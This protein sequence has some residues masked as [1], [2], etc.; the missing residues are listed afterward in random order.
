MKG[1]QTKLTVPNFIRGTL[2]PINAAFSLLVIRYGMIKSGFIMIFIL[3]GVA[4]LALSR[5][6]ESFSK[7]LDYLEVS[8]AAEVKL[9]V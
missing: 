4:L 2:I 7:D 5:L 6:K 1:Q 8:E 3:T 9:A